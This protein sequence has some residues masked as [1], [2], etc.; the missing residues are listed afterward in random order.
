MLLA[1]VLEALGLYEESD[2][3]EGL[4]ALI[5]VVLDCEAEVVV[6]MASVS[7][8]DADWEPLEEGLG[9]ARDDGE[10]LHIVENEVTAIALVDV[11]SKAL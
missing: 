2:D 3:S 5:E 10:C 11:T 4:V 1:R 9:V 8:L 6:D 7:I